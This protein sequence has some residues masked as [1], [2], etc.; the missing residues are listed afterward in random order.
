MEIKACV[1][2]GLVI[3]FELTIAMSWNTTKL[4]DEG[5]IGATP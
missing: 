1:G 5:R 3:L 2:E 4:V